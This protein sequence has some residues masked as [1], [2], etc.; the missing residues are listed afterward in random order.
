MFNVLN[1]GVINN[2]TFDNTEKL[3]ALLDGIKETGGLLYFPAGKYLTASLQLYSN[4]TIYLEAGATIL[5][6]G[7]MSKYPVIT[8]ELVPGFKRGTARGILFV[9]SLKGS[10]LKRNK[11]FHKTGY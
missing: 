5:A 10:S 3:Q 9:D 8:E 11:T 1:Y 7:D 4:T 2:G 6:S